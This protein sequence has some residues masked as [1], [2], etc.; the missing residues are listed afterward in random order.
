MMAGLRKAK[1]SFSS[2]PVVERQIMCPLQKLRILPVQEYIVCSSVNRLQFTP[3]TR[4]VTTIVAGIFSD[5]MRFS[6][7][8]ILSN[9]GLYMGSKLSWNSNQSVEIYAGGFG[10]GVKDIASDLVMDWD[11]AVV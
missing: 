11:L 9:A 10:L 1:L 6:I 5:N 7:N 3:A 2:I 4:S 8:S